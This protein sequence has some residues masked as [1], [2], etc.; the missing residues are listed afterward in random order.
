MRDMG[1]VVLWGEAEF[2]SLDFDN[3]N[4]DA[5]VMRL[6]AHVGYDAGKLMPYLTVGITNFSINGPGT[7]FPKLVFPQGWASIT[8]PLKSSSWGLNC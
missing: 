3:L 8:W 5:N 4:G 6:K 2:G 1:A 7:T